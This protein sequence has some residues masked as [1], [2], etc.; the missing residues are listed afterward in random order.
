MSGG[1][2]MWQDF[3][4]AMCLVLI[5]EGMLPFL[6]PS[7][8]RSLVIKLAEVDNASMRLAGF[9]SMMIG[10]ALLMLVRD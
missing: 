9:I 1:F 3:A 6:A 4:T 10:L 5:L 8:W 2:S 7:R